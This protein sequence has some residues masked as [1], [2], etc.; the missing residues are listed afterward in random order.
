MLK[1]NRNGRV[2]HLVLNRPESRN[3]LNSEMVSGL[4]TALRAMDTDEQIGA[5]VLEGSPPGFCA[6]SDLKELGGLDISRI[7]Q[8]E[9]FTACVARSIATISK[10]VLAAVEGF[11][12]GGGLVLAASCD[13]V[14]TGRAA[15]WFLPEVSLGWVPPWG[16]SALLMRTTLSSARL[17]VLGTEPS[18]GA[19]AHRLGLADFVV[20]DGEVGATVSELA[21]RMSKLPA[22]AVASTKRAF[23]RSSLAH[24]EALDAEA[25]NLFASDARQP[26]GQATLNRFMEKQ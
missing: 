4:G 13:V 12:I 23:A 6:G 26:S 11:A 24:A 1:V 25:N 9:A 2:A 18:T 21:Q 22:A 3:A 8:H 14:V 19:D 7:S 17:L 20:A 15:K 16:L 10:P 5:I